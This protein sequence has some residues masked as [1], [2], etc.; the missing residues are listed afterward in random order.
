MR[1]MNIRLCQINPG[2]AL[3]TFTFKC[4][5]FCIAAAVC[6]ITGYINGGG[7]TFTMFVVGTVVCF[8]VD[9][10]GFASASGIH[11]VFCRTFILTSKTFTG[12]IVCVTGFCTFYID[13]AFGTERILVV[14]AVMG[15]TF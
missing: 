14:A 7:G 8:A 3:S 5:A 1:I 11:G 13:G 4:I 9:V 6:I 10:D 2:Q 15:G 12:S